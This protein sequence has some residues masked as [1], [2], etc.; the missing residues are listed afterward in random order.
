MTF[1][2]LEPVIGLRG[3]DGAGI[4]DD[5]IRLL[6]AIDAHGSISAA[7]RNVGLT[8]KAAWDAV[9]AINNLAERPLVVGRTGG[10]AGGGASLTEDGRRF[11]RSVQF[12]QYELRRL[13]RRLGPELG[14]DIVLPT[15]SWRFLMRTS[16]RN[17]LL[18]KV[19]E[20]K[21]GAVNAEIILD[22]SDDIRLV[23]IITEE[24]V[25][26]LGLKPEMEV[27]ALIKSSFVLLA[28]KGEIGRTS[29]RN[30]ILGTI[31]RREDGAVNSE[32]ILDIGD[33][34]TLAAI[35]T[36]ESAQSLDFKVGDRA[37]ALIKASH[38]ILAID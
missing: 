13:A 1:E 22:V 23:A 26:A 4:G 24:S 15:L 20:V 9:A 31:A 25:K 35:I 18:C 17:M 36:K 14:K 21:P 2:Q 3:K 12:M 27:F 29:A 32:I 30:V 6:E 34:K 7:A 37:S 28:P 10:R 11:L 16:A 33:G 8:Y 5:R 19:A 38:I